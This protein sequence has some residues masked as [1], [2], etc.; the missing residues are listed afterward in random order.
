MHTDTQACAVGR[1]NRRNEARA[2][3]KLDRI[4]AMANANRLRTW[5]FAFKNLMLKLRGT[6]NMMDRARSHSVGFADIAIASIAAADDIDVLTANTKDFGPLGVQF[7]NPFA[8]GLPGLGPRPRTWITL[9]PHICPVRHGPAR[10][11][12]NVAAVVARSR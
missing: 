11:I 3:L 4:E 6:Q 1:D 5:L 9:Q 8:D 7:L 10:V 12:G 2:L